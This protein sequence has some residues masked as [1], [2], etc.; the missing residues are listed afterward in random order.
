METWTV[1]RILDWGI[2]FFKKKDIPQAR[3][4]A[5]LLLAAVLGLTRMEL[6]LGLGRVLKPEE[7][8]AYK[9][10]ILRRL[11]HEP[12][13]Y[14]L[15]QAHFRNLSLYVDENVLIPRPETE[16]VVD[17]ALKAA[18]DILGRKKALNIVEIGTGSGAISLSLYTELAGKVKG[19]AGD[20]KITATDI[21]EKALEVA[22]RNAANILSGG[23]Q[24]NI[25][26]IQCDIIP[27]IKSQWFKDNKGKVD[28]VVS[29]PPY[30]TESG[31]KDLPLEIKEYEPREALLAGKSGLEIYEKILSGIEGLM[32][33]D[34]CIILETDP[35]VGGKLAEM[36]VKH[37][38][39]KKVT[40]E[41]DYNQKDRLLCIL[42]G[43]A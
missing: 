15:G 30:V 2:G 16:I 20:I 43:R 25:E 21:S 4:S 11:E 10:H 26:F 6:Y 13:Q 24:D 27:D 39:G 19:A 18:S 12:I 33:E 8:A 36:V 41:K 37:F 14:I 29:N 7:L 38:K 34:S 3:L 5:E 28:L 35:V 42:N 22:R 40:L 31:F 23:R 1:K 17:K 32:A 9:S